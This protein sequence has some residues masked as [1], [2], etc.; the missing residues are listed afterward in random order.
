MVAGNRTST[1]DRALEEGCLPGYPIT[2]DVFQQFADVG[3]LGEDDRVEL[4]EGKLV[5]M[6]PIGDPHA[7]CVDLLGRLLTLAVGF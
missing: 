7:D 6:S 5:Q 4:L 1:L 2:A 3:L